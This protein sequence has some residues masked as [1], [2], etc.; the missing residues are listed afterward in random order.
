MRSIDKNKRANYYKTIESN[1]LEKKIAWIQEPFS[2]VDLVSFF[3][4]GKLSRF[5]ILST[6]EKGF[7]LSKRRSRRNELELFTEK[8]MTVKEIAV[9]LKVGESSVKRAVEKLRPVLGAVALNKQGGYLFTEKQASLLKQE[10]EK[11][12]NLAI[13][14]ID[15]VTTEL[16]E[17]QM[18]QKGYALAVQK[19]NEYKKRAEQAEAVV[20][21]IADS[22]GLKSI[23]EVAD[24]LGYGEKTY[25]ATLRGLG[26]LFK[27]NGVNLPK[28]EYINQ[29]YFEVKEEPYERNG[30]TY[31][32]SRVYVTA[33]GLLWLEK[34]TPKV[35]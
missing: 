4:V 12:H 25:F 2:E 28:R 24:I 17:M 15:Y 13:R 26:I 27:D 18:I 35:A 29:G 34:K 22:S 19:M 5:I 23:K 9:E 10:L 1:E 20:N 32:Y 16:E 30:N 11:H 14:Q 6:S 7:F 31:L 33:K 3:H 8:T 21:R